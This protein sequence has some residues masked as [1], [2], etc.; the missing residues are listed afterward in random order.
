MEETYSVQLSE[1]EAKLTAA[2]QKILSDEKLSLGSMRAQYLIAEARTLS[3]IEGMEKD[4]L[5]HL[6]MLAQSKGISLEQN[7]VY[8]IATSSFVKK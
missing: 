3:R 1:E 8:D 4:L 7:W 6:R 5:S 2:Y